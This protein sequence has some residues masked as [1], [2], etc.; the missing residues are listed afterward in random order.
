MTAKE[1]LKQIRKLDTMIRNKMAEK[2]QWKSVAF[3]ITG[4]TD[5]ERVQSSG[6]QQKMASAVDRYV[7]IEREI[8]EYVDQLIDAKREVIATIELLDTVEY[9]LL[10]KVYVQ[11][12]TLKELAIESGNSESWA[13]TTHGRALQHLQE[14]LNRKE[15]DE[16]KT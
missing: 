6:N 12:Y 5:G 13:T 14:V 10:H 1:F 8:D 4:R 15:Q 2:D 16:Q 3:G 9:D 11:N 7:D